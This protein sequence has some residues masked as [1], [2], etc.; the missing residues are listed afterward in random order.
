[1][2][3]YNLY[4]NAENELLDLLRLEDPLGGSDDLL[5]IYN[6]KETY[7]FLPL[8]L[9]PSRSEVNDMLELIRMQN[10]DH[11]TPQLST[12]SG[13]RSSIQQADF[14]FKQTASTHES[15]VALEVLPKRTPK[16]AQYS[17]GLVEREIFLHSK[18]KIRAPR[19]M[20]FDLGDLRSSKNDVCFDLFGIRSSPKY[21]QTHHEASNPWCF[22]F[23]MDKE[24]LNKIYN[25]VADFGKISA[26][27]LQD[28]QPTELKILEKM[29]WLRLTAVKAIPVSHPQNLL[30]NLEILNLLLG[31]SI[32]SKKRTEEQLKKHFKTVLKIMH[33]EFKEKFQDSSK[34][35]SS[36]TKSKNAFLDFYFGTEKAKFS[37]LFKCVQMSREF[38]AQIFSNSLF[39]SQFAKCAEGFMEQFLAERNAKTS[40]L[41]NSISHELL[42]NTESTASLR[43]PW[44]VVEATAADQ[45]MKKLLL[46]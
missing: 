28:L 41:I 34:K 46:A 40:N 3:G 29:L 11:S 19:R 35:A 25:Q 27:Q 26:A 20:S 21:Q 5:S 1:M 42:S 17:S 6:M 24:N 31:K 18:L 16:A 30:E 13:S 43:T 37:K 9:V 32:C 14:T 2:L 36:E 22:D 7:D 8:E 10:P 38:Y 39:Q 23:C 4:S 45:Q 44:T 33:D 12:G 15:S